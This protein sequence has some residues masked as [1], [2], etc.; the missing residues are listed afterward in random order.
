MKPL[1]CKSCF[2][3]RNTF[4]TKEF[5]LK[6]KA[7]LSF[8]LVLFTAVNAFSNEASDS[9]NS[10]DDKLFESLCNTEGNVNYSALSVVISAYAVYTNLLKEKINH[11]AENFCHNS[12]MPP[13]SS[14]CV[15]KLNSLNFVLWQPVNISNRFVTVFLEG[16]CPD[17]IIIFFVKP[18]VLSSLPPSQLLAL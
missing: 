15:T 4:T 9:V 1:C 11:C 8:M 10:F 2:L 5:I 18:K 3:Y 6:R 13:F 17:I 16:D 14:K 7:F 12:L